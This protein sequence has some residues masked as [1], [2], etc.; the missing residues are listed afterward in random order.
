MPT[1]FE[2]S[3]HLSQNRTRF[4]L[5]LIQYLGLEIIKQIFKNTRISGKLFLLK[6]RSRNERILATAMF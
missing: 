6:K 1:E 3:L 5:G 4:V 2:K